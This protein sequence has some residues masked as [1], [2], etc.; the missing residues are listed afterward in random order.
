[1]QPY[2]GSPANLAVYTA[3][4]KPGERLMG[5]DL[6]QGGHLTHGFYSETKKVSATS[7]FWESKQ[8][9]VNLKTGYIDYD[10][11]EQNALE[12]KPKIIIAG[13]SAYPRD[14]DYKRFREIC[15]KVGAYLLADIAHISGLIAAKELNNPFE[16]AHVVSTTTHKSLRGPRAAMIFARKELMEQI[17]FAVFPMLQGGPHDHQIAAIAA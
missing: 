15:D 10:A 6:T 12:F 9:K 14:L 5:L 13:F 16:Y 11:L 7:L 1:M 17:D 3:L 8:Y 4:L 2:S